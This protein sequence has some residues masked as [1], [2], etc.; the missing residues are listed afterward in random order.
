MRTERKWM[1][2]VLA[3]S[4]IFS[5]SD[6]AL[7]RSG[8]SS[9]DSGAATTTADEIVNAAIKSV[10]EDDWPT[11]ESKFREAMRAEPKQALWHIQ[12]T[13]ALSQ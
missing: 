13:L 10:N 6:S 8:N 11:A 7:S 3:L 2:A 4:L 12:L 5:V 9:Q 1:L